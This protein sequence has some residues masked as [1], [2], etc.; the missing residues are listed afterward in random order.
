MGIIK[1]TS[2][3]FIASFSLSDIVKV[4]TPF[5]APVFGN[6][7]SGVEVGESGE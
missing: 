4:F 2:K 7:L 1:P 5:A 3:T 6:A